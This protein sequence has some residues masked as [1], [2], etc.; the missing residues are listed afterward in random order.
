[1]NS[2]DFLFLVLSFCTLPLASAE[3]LDRVEAV[4]NK[5][6][7]Y[8]SDVE[9]FRKLKPLR[10]K[11]DPIFSSDPLSRKDTLTESEIVSFLVDEAIVVEK[12]PIPESEVEQEING[13]QG[14]LKIDRESLKSAIAREGFKFDDYFKLMRTSLAKRQLLDHEI[15]NKATVSE[16]DLTAEY[17][18]A[19]AGSKSFRGAFHLSIIRVTKKNYK[20]PALAK[21]EALRAFQSIKDGT[22]FE[23]VAKKTSDDASQQGGGDLGFLSYSEMNPS[24]QKEVQRLGPNKLSDLIEDQKSYLIVKIG[25]IKAEVDPEFEKEKDSLR[26]KLMEGEFQHQIRLWLDRQRTLNFVTIN[27]K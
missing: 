9:H 10:S 6:A 5:K 21:E 2:Q 20:T 4:V 22:G 3:V 8:K 1:M 26:G 27:K 7:I 23:E 16:D 11:V 15:R 24:I 19:H 17:N 25:E 14:N 18:R 12:F 13:I